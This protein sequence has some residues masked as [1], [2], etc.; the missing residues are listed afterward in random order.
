MFER[1][2]TAMQSEWRRFEQERA[3]WDVER[4]KFKAKISA[5][6]KRIAHLSALY[7]ASQKHITIL[8]SVLKRDQNTSMEVRGD[9]LKSIEPSLD[10]LVNGDSSTITVASLVE[11]TAS[12]R[13]RSRQL[14]SRCLQEIDV[15]MT[16]T[17]TADTRKQ[18]NSSS[19]W[20]LWQYR[21]TTG[22]ESSLSR[23]I[24]ESERTGD[25]PIRLPHVVAAATD[26]S[27]EQRQQRP[28]MRG[29]SEP[30]QP[31]VS[32]PQQPSPLVPTPVSSA[33]IVDDTSKVLTVDE[34]DDNSG[35]GGGLAGSEWTVARTFVGH[36]DTVR[37]VC[38]RMDGNDASKKAPQLLTGSDDGMLMLW[39]LEGEE[40]RRRASTS[41]R[42]RRQAQRQPEQF[43]WQRETSGNSSDVVSGPVAIFRG[44]LAGI[45]SVV[46]S[47]VQPLAYSGSLDSRIGVWR[48]HGSGG[49][50]FAAGELVGHTDAVWDLALNARASL[51]ASVSADATCKLWSTTSNTTSSGRS[52]SSS[53]SSKDSAS[54]LTYMRDKRVVPTSVC[55]TTEDGSR[56]AIGYADGRIETYDTQHTSTLMQTTTTAASNKMLLNTRIT[57]I[58]CRPEESEHVVGAACADGSVHLFDVRSGKTVLSPATGITAYPQRGIAATAVDLWTGNGHSSNGGAMAVVTGGSDGVV[59]WWDWRRALASVHEVRAHQRKGDEGVCAVCVVPPSAS[60]GMMVASAGSDGSAKIFRNIL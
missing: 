6:E 4:I 13:E 57:K 56:L 5:M 52:S 21:D 36:M 37:A 16:N 17:S 2:M 49:D 32:M 3:S 8:E 15:L 18:S 20:D 34:V 24:I 23:S 31:T 41:S 46:S 1:A 47:L 7:G 39:D 45:T 35:G 58:V 55:F 51:L 33:P 30:P 50:T 19:V 29:V 12:T 11:A 53:S 40:Q 22:S 42:L 25:E 48:I 59:R 14:L 28:R 43:Q 10:P 44:H 27:A 9:K 38:V 26:V 60:S 54:T